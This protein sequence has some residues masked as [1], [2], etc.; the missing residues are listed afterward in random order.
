[1]AN[2]LGSVV[3]FFFILDLHPSSKMPSVMTVQLLVKE[4]CVSLCSLCCSRCST[5]KHSWIPPK[6]PWGFCSLIQST[7]LFFSALF[8]FQRGDFKTKY[9]STQTCRVLNKVIS[10][11]TDP[12][13]TRSPLRSQ[14][15]HGP[16]AQAGGLSSQG[17]AEPVEGCLKP[18][19]LPRLLPYQ[20]GT[21]LRWQWQ[22][23]WFLLLPRTLSLQ[24]HC[25]LGA[26]G[27]EER[28]WNFRQRVT[29]K[30]TVAV[31]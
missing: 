1:M 8:F 16:A 18:L 11:M 7:L 19:I 28:G 25:I 22:A 24:G 12:G 26:V 31:H 23:A 2:S 3:C 17:D 4:W 6:D 27:R 30:L 29:I 5:A 9:W 13:G 20:A 10:E 21:F 15:P 14:S